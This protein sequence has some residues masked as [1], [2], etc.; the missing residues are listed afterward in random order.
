MLSVPQPGGGQTALF[1][2]GEL[3]PAKPLGHAVRLSLSVLEVQDAARAPGEGSLT[4]TEGVFPSRLF[5]LPEKSPLSKTLGA[6][7]QLGAAES[8]T[9]IRKGANNPKSVVL[10]C[11]QS[12][13]CL[14]QGFG[15]PLVLS[16]LV[17]AV[18]L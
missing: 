8:T 2:P 4:P 10:C 1:K 12:L 6:A 3:L 9:G 5:S 7:A 17:H 16:R 14:L 18:T 13:S 11:V 15:L